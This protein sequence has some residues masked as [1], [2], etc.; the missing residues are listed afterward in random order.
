MIFKGS[1]VALVT[2]FNQNNEINYLM[3]KNLIE[4]QIASGTKAI[5]ILGTT[6]ESATITQEERTK[7]IKFCVAQIAKRI[8]L[9]VGTGSNSTQTAI[10]HSKEA[11]KLGADA[12]LVVTPYYN[13]TSQE[14]LILHYK[15]I[16]KSV[17]LPLIIYNVP[18][19]T[20]VNISTDSILKLSQVK[21]IVGLKD[22]GG[23]INQSI[24]LLQK[25]PKGFSLYSGDDLITYPLMTLGYHGVISVTA[26]AYP[27][28][29]SAMCEDLLNKNYTNALRL[30]K[31]LYDINRALFLDINP[32]CIKYYLKLIGK[33]VGNPRLPLTLPTKNTRDKLN[34]IMEIY[35]H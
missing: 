4:F 10:L 17:N 24:E 9:I 14:G 29:V 32:I 12:I 26:N 3:L 33:N 31:Y 30:H 11:K 35:E 28:I 6:G 25:L 23:N 7:I 34:K 20:G 13:K 21:N 19:R 27:D 15:S 16:A 18:S 8:P 22:A 2:P 5:V 1:S